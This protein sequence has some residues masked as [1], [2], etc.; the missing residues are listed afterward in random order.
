M[1]GAWEDYHTPDHPGRLQVHQNPTGGGNAVG[2]RDSALQKDEKE[3]G[4]DGDLEPRRVGGAAVEVG[5]VHAERLR[6][7]GQGERPVLS[8]GDGS[9]PDMDRGRAAALDRDRQGARR[10]S[11]LWRRAAGVGGGNSAA[12]HVDCRHLLQAR[13]LNNP[14]IVTRACRE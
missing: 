5:Q 12:A 13:D 10:N 1:R 3:D 14:G 4:A 7:P 9:A 8:D 2:D 11:P 6:A